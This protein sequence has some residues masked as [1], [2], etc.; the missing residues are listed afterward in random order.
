[1]AGV[2]YRTLPTPQLQSPFIG[3]V[4]GDGHLASLVLQVAII[5]GRGRVLN[6]P[7]SLALRRTSRAQANTVKQSLVQ[8]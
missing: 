4:S 2:G 7:G 8:C 1:M 5:I 3:P 6:F